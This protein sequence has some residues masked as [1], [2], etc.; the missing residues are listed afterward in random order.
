MKQQTKPM[1]LLSGR[2]QVRE[3]EDFLSILSSGLGQHK[4][5]GCGMMLIRPA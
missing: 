2:L 3:P 5:F 1:V 4:S